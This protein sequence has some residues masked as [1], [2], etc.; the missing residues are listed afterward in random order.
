M[1]HRLLLITLSI[2][3]QFST[4]YSILAISIILFC[5]GSHAIQQDWELS[6][7]FIIG[8]QAQ[9]FFVNKDGTELSLTKGEIIQG[10]QLVDVLSEAVKLHCEEEVHTLLL[11][12]SVGD[13]H[14]Q[15]QFQS[16]QVSKQTIFL[17]KDEL[18]DYA[19]QRQR[20]ASEIGFLPLLEDEK[21]IGFTISK[22]SPG[23]PV[24]KLGL[25]NG[26]VITSINGVAA[27]NTSQF[28]EAINELPSASQVSIHVDRYGQNLAYTYIFE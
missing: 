7:T 27:S 28:L 19:N 25:Y 26:D 15:A 22:V 5:S 13:I 11:R 3:T 10:C 6:G 23:T 12:N 14:K 1:S 18:K 17:P 2:F 8:K 20:I 9:A 21:V 4:R 24:S 16:T